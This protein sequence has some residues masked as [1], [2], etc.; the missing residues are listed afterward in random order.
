LVCDNFAVYFGEVY[1]EKYR[2]LIS[3]DRNV[4]ITLKIG[5]CSRNVEFIEPVEQRL[6]KNLAFLPWL[7]P[8]RWRKTWTTELKDEGR[9]A[10]LEVT[11]YGG[12]AAT[13]EKYSP[14]Y[15]DQL[16]KPGVEMWGNGRMFSLE[17]RI[18]DESVG[19]GYTYGGRGGRNPTSNAS[20]RRLTA[21]ALFSAEDSRDIPW[22]APVKNDYNRRSDFYAEIKETLARV[23]RLFKDA[24]ALLDFVLLP[25]SYVWT[26]YDDQEKLGILFQD[27][28][29]SP[30]FIQDFAESRFGKKVLAFHPTLTFKDIDNDD[31]NPPTNDSLYRFGSIQIKDLGDAAV[32]TKQQTGA[33]RVKFLEAIFP[34]LAKQAAIEEQ[35]GLDPEE[36]TL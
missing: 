19:W 4:S 11:I 35:I 20:Y 14:K 31:G 22:A 30:K 18:T 13:P 3:R 12:L 2:D 15:Q 23:I 32:A 17:G 7:R 36:F 34:G 9:T 29:A 26:E 24:H 5:D 33:Q 25:F 28:V 21:I 10:K 16:S 6:L 8:I 1:A 27:T